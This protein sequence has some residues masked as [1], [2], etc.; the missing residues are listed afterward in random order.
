MKPGPIP[1]QTLAR[2]AFPN[3]NVAI[4]TRRIEA[5]CVIVLDGRELTLTHTVLEGHR[6]ATRYIAAG[7]NLLS[8]GLPFGRAI[9]IMEPGEYVCNELMI[10]ALKC[11][12]VAMEIPTRANFEDRIEPYALD[13]ERFVPGPPVGLHGERRSFM[14][15]RR[16]GA[17]GVGTR[18]TVV[19][20]GTTSRTA[21]IAREIA[22][23]LQPLAAAYP[24]MDGIVAVSHTE[25]GDTQVPNN[26]LE[27]HRALSGFMLHPN[28]GAVVAL[29]FGVEPV[30]NRT[31]E[32]FMRAEGGGLEHVLH[33]FVTLEGS[34]AAG[35]SHVEEWVR[36]CIA[37]VAA[38]RRT[39]EPLDGLIIGLQC[40]GSD[41]FSGISGNPL[42]GAVVH[43]VLRHGGA[44]VLCETDELVGAEGYVL[45]SARD[46]PTA[47]ALLQVIES[48]KER[49]SWHGVTAESN[50]SAGNNLRGLYNIVLKSLGAAHKKDPRSRVEQV[51]GYGEPVRRPGFHFMNS[52]GN[53]LEGIAG[54]VASGCNLFLFVTG[55][56]S[57][58]NFPFVPTIK[59]TTTT[60]RHRLLS[61]EMDV[62]AGRYLDGESMETLVAETLE[63]VI[64]SASGRRTKGER[65]GHSQVSIWRNWRQTDGSQLNRLR[66]RP[67]PRG[68]PVLERDAA[69]AALAQMSIGFPAVP[70][71]ACALGDGRW[72]TERVGLVFPTSLCSTQ[73][74]RRAAERMNAG[75]LGK[76]HGISR[77]VAPVHTEGCGY[78]SS[79]M[80][81]LL[82][83]TYRAYATHPNVAAALFLEHG[84]EK[85][86]NDVMRRHLDAVS[87]P[88]DQF[89][90]ASVQ[91]DGGIDR[92][93]LKIER[94]FRE[95]LENS[96]PLAPERRDIGSL[97]VAIQTVGGLLPS[98]YETL[99]CVMF[100]VVAKGGTV[101]IA[102]SDPIWEGAP[103]LGRL[104]G[105]P[106]DPSLL[107]GE[108]CPVAGLHVVSTETTDW[109]ENLAGLAACG[110]HL[111]VSAVSIHLR[112]G[113]PLIPV[114]QFEGLGA[115]TATGRAPS[116]ID[117]V[118]TSDIMRDL[119]LIA[120]RISAV[121]AGTYF[122]VADSL[123]LT[124]FQL[125]RGLLGIST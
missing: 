54:Q 89:G 50:P 8:W 97:S 48:F 103:S 121:T 25:G 91:L 6:F 95:N 86:P 7:E 3:D 79:T 16:D 119:T 85:I 23:R 55:N 13:E 17:R 40:G 5:G 109:S 34:L 59:I 105:K 116:Q 78:G 53:D 10:R 81:E 64:A 120:D 51:I 27:I 82:L 38:F 11:R 57:I 104:F 70:A 43:E 96:S 56:G 124:H 30:N 65:A 29:D 36:G 26:A 62:N 93:L 83:R 67:R 15:Y 114:L 107:Y 125:T 63:L 72:S 111:A 9:R 37:Q 77:F 94:W 99:A 74:A 106:V 118:L 76:A 66:A 41:A 28:V 21:G 1:F 19:I 31:L 73:I 113:H 49:L 14:G 44:G 24:A 100:G 101:L 68:T 69:Q 84:C 90:W 98:S 122:P 22:D 45:E 12:E 71:T 47:R 112:E 110:A 123:G 102:D 108:V 87:V 80:H 46:L 18:N 61:R 20:L 60:E 35:Y 75:G 39:P 42:A 115:G 52:P 32:A 33:D 58:T 117:G 2:L 4:A 88:G 92:A